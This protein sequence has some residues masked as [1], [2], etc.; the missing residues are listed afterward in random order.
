MTVVANIRRSTAMPAAMPLPAHD[1][2]RRHASRVTAMRRLAAASAAA[3]AFSGIM[4]AATNTT[5][6]R[7]ADTSP[8]LVALFTTKVQPLILNKCAAGACHGGPSAHAPRFHRG[9]I[10]G[11]IDRG[12]TLANIESLTDVVGPHGDLS[13]FLATISRR[14]PAGAAATSLQLTPLT[15]QERATLE[16]WLAA[17]TGTTAGSEATARGLTA[18]P[19]TAS[20]AGATQPVV[21]P[22]PNRFRA[23]LEAAANPLPLPA[24]QEPQGIILGKGR[25]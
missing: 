8:Q 20:V 22:R 5:A 9:D 16:R 10:A 15:P 6:A 11:P 21:A 13:A 25:D 23:M 3:L 24:P 14:H 12:S 7:A 4:S 1:T 18:K 2:P 19:P 17:A